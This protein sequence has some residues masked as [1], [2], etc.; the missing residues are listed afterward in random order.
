[1][2][3]NPHQSDSQQR[4]E[5]SR[6]LPGLVDRDLTNDRQRTLQEFVMNEINDRR[7]GEAPR[8]VPRARF[9]LATTAVIAVAA[10][11]AV[12]I[13]Y[14]QGE[15]DDAGTKETA[16]PSTFELAAD[17]A[18]EQSFDPPGSDQW[19]YVE[20]KKLFPG[21][22][23]EDKGQDP[24]QTEQFWMSVDGK[25]MATIDPETG[26]LDTW[27]QYNEY[28][29]LSTLPTD[30]EKLLE[31]LREGL[32]NSGPDC[33]GADNDDPKCDIEKEPVG[34]KE[35]F[36]RV[37]GIMSQH[38]LPPKVEA[39]L[40]KAA[41]LI[42]GVTEEEIIEVDGKEVIAVG[43]VADGW[44][45]QQILVDPETYAFFGIRGEAIKDHDFP[46]GDGETVKI[47]KG[48]VQFEH[49]RLDASVVDEPGDTD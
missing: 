22:I 11:T 42:P 24:D 41:A 26:K 36:D 13:G 44:E 25:K 49:V 20:T 48:E 45:F 15:G 9:A 33:E 4:E 17:Y 14:A 38:L 37:T 2:N 29:E 7:T 40:W 46:G 19:I 6:M 34:D 31:K 28:P 12:T 8:R 1:M 47:K 43:R 30:P 35:L 32:E 3:T 16:A 5:L 39:A 23:S 27:N 10:I 21:S 18:S